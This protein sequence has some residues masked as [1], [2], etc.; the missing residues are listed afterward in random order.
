MSSQTKVDG[1][2][3]TVDGPLM[4]FE[5]NEWFTADQGPTIT[6]DHQGYQGMLFAPDGPT[7][8]TAT[9]VLIAGDGGLVW[10]CGFTQLYDDATAQ[11]WREAL[12]G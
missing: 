10:S 11:T 4:T 3:T 7:L 5:V 12:A 1:T 6:L 2:V 9:R 8:D